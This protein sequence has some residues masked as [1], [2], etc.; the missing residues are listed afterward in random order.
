M[1]GFRGRA[2]TASDHAYLHLNSLI[3]PLGF[4][5]HGVRSCVIT[6]QQAIENVLQCRAIFSTSAICVFSSNKGLRHTVQE[7]FRK[8]PIPESEPGKWIK[9]VKS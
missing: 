1:W 3:A 2:Q 9:P 4:A 5:S 6:L 7:K 8:R